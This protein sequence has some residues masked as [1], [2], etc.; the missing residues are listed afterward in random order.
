MSRREFFLGI[1]LLVY[2]TSCFF[3][4]FFLYHTHANAPTRPRLDFLV[5]TKCTTRPRLDF[6][7]EPRNTLLGGQQHVIDFA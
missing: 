1:S 2:N 6:L 5:G 7:V 3:S 4:D